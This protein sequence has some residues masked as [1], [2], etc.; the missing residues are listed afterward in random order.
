ME[1]RTITRMALLALATAVLAAAGCS[2]GTHADHKAEALDRWNAARSGINYGL[3][4]QQ[5]EVGELNK[6]Q[7][8]IVKTLEASPDEPRYHVLAARIALEKGELERAFRHLELATE[9][10]PTFAPGHYYMGVVFQ[11]WQQYDKA[12]QAYEL[13]YKHDPEN[14]DGLIAVGE[15][16][17][18]LGRPDQAVA[19]LSEKLVYFEHN[20]SLRLSIARIH[21]KQ[22]NMD[23]A[24]EAFREAYL[25]VPDDVVVLEQL[26]M[27]EYAAGA[28]SEAIYHRSQLLEDEQMSGRR[29][30]RLALGDCYQRTD[31]PVLARKIFMELTH[32]DPT[33]VAA[34]IK[35]GQAA[36][37]VG[38]RVRLAEAAKMVRSL[39][40]QRPEGHLLAGM[41]AE[42]NGDNAQAIAAYTR[43]AEADPTTALPHILIGLVHERSGDFEAATAAYSRATKVDPD[44]ARARRLLAGLQAAATP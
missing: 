12:L 13:S 10:D 9:A 20:A 11:R 21:L 2:S 42:V 17:V 28:F 4:V 38:D 40:P 26:A 1:R 25:L 3:A 34:W 14:V 22:R 39:E 8:T 19:R 7:R 29:D 27:A 43:A 16:L 44:D 35:L 33:D 23:K 18:K 24:L 30:L 31:R 37:I 36:K 32:E 5:F 41:V 6:A 15:M